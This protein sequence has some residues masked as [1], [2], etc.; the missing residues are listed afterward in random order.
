MVK[1]GNTPSWPRVWESRDLL[2]LSI[3]WTIANGAKLAIV[4]LKRD[5]CLSLNLLATVRKTLFSYLSLVFRV[6]ILLK[7]YQRELAI[8]IKDQP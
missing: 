3:R 7:K 5:F 8:G 2:S 1:L 4:R 6:I